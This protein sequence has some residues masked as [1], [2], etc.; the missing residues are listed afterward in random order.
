ME[1]FQCSSDHKHWTGNPA[2]VE[3]TSATVLQQ[4]S[5]LIRNAVISQEDIR[6]T[7]LLGSSKE[8]SLKDSSSS[9]SSYNLTV[10]GPLIF[11]VLLSAHFQ[12]ISLPHRAEEPQDTQVM[13]FYILTRL[14]LKAA[15]GQP[16]TPLSLQEVPPHATGQRFNSLTSSLNTRGALRAERQQGYATTSAAA[17]RQSW[18]LSL[19]SRSPCSGLLS[20]Q[21]IL[22]QQPC[23]GKLNL[24]SP[25]CWQDDVG[26]LATDWLWREPC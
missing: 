20:R 17:G 15:E 21:N 3:L 12:V 23:V 9:L 4:S 24:L 10:K 11:R 13:L 18:G 8:D 1:K 19:G 7:T 25:V 5:I 2:M 6:L 22:I 14:F 26:I 16:E